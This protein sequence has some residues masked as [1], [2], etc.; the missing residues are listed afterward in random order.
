MEE[1]FLATVRS[2]VAACAINPNAFGA[3]R[4]GKDICI[5]GE[6]HPANVFAPFDLPRIKFFAK[7]QLVWIDILGPGTA[8]GIRVSI[9]KRGKSVL[10]CSIDD[11]S[12]GFREPGFYPE[13]KIELPTH[14]TFF[15]QIKLGLEDILAEMMRT[16]QLVMSFGSAGWFSSRIEA[17]VKT[18]EE[19]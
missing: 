5:V 8:K 11:G 6:K 12:E 18:I 14:D 7:H 4:M 1:A 13:R 10:S 9:S 19:M 15:E 17:A 2:Q 16:T 3:Q